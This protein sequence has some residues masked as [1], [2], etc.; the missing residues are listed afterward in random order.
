MNDRDSGAAPVAVLDVGKTNVKLS[1][2]GADGTLVET[3]SVP[4]PADRKS[5]V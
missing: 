3:I 5:V 1:A 2:V 4:N